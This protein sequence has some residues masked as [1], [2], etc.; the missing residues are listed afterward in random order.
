M[1][2][3]CSLGNTLDVSMEK[4]STLFVNQ[5]V[6]GI[7]GSLK[8]IQWHVQKE[9]RRCRELLEAGNGTREETMTRPAIMHKLY[10]L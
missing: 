4:Y 10:T 9:P 7:S 6:C 1:A 3:G 2:L 5:L 8:L